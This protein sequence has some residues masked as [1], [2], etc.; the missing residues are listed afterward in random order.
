MDLLENHP[1]FIMFA[2]LKI[3]RQGHERSW[4]HM[5][6]VVVGMGSP[7]P[8]QCTGSVLLDMDPL[9]MGDNHGTRQQ[10]PSLCGKDN[11]VVTQGVKG[12]S[13]YHYE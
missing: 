12:T 5:P 8:K 9:A 6:F 4:L 7:T 11:Q 3:Q 13:Y 10:V 2:H 1:G